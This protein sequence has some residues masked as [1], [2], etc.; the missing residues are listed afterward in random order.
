MPTDPSQVQGGR[1]GWLLVAALATS[2]TTSYGVLAYAFAVFLVPMQQELGW[3]RTA[4]TGA[5]SAAII[6]SGLAAI[7]VGRWLDRHGARALMTVGS[8]AAAL[9]VLAWAQVSDLTAFYA[10]WV[11]I[12]L[13][14]ATVLYEPAFAVI[15]TWFDDAERRRALL[16]LTVIAGFASAIYVPLAGWL[17]QVHGWRDALIVLAAL[18]GLLSVLPNA[19]LPTRRPDHLERPTHDEDSPP[20]GPGGPAGVPLRQA[21]GDQ[22]LWWL[23]G[24]LVA[25]TLATSTVSVHL[26]AYLREQHYSPGFAATWTGLLGAMS[27]TGRIVVTVLGRRWAL[28]AATAGIFALQ[29]VAVAILLVMPGPAG[30]VGFVALF[31]LGVGLIS[32][33]RAAL[34]A[35]VYGVAAY[36]SINGVLALPLTLAR[37]AAPV[38]AAGLRATTGNYRLVMIAVALC[39][40]AASLAMA[41]THQLQG[42]RAIPAR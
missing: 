39:S 10:I 5:Y 25:A 27:V 32:L 9:L 18:L 13:T 20:A 6:A 40:V 42:R 16:T 21:L 30:V 31:G 36:A 15:A 3:S 28:A 4:L 22:A 34:V 11:G 1:R 8:A 37:A 41:R 23:A 19:T 38:A 7:P 12:G 29:A 17:V 14:M 2:E 26:V 35:E 33:V 24:A